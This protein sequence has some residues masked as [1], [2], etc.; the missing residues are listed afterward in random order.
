MRSM[1]SDA[2]VRV[3][4]PAQERSARMVELDEPHLSFAEPAAPAERDYADRESDEARWAHVREAVTSLPQGQR[5]CV[6]L[7][8]CWG[9]YEGPHYR[10]VPLEDILPILQKA[11][12]GG[13]V[14]PF[15]NPRHQHEY[16]V[17]AK[18]PL[19]DDQVIA[20]GVIDDLTVEHHLRAVS[21]RLRY[22]HGRRRLRHHDDR[23]DAKTLGVIGDRLGMI[24][25]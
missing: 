11:N 9:N 14:F 21:G 25:G 1:E 4:P 20:A 7:H 24:A 13:F 19:A 17:L 18:Y 16:R 6:R 3:A 15:A 23:R 2:A 8:V 12:V 5:D 22:L 10:D